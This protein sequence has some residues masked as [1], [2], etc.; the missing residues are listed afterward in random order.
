M[1]DTFRYM[2][3]IINS[4][5]GHYKVTQSGS[6]LYPR[7]GGVTSYEQANKIDYWRENERIEDSMYAANQRIKIPK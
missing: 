7:I 4:W 3:Q 1:I 2:Q 6:D 5:D